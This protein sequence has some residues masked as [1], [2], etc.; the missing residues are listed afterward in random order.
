M[1]TAYLLFGYYMVDKDDDDDDHHHPLSL[2]HSSLAGSQRN[3]DLTNQASLT[4]CHKI[5]AYT[6]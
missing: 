3:T 4:H 6:A 5:S 1:A 2:L